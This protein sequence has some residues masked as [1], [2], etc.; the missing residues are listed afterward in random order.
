MSSR[1][2]HEA[3][4][5]HESATVKGRKNKNRAWVLI[6]LAIAVV[7]LAAF[8]YVRYMGFTT[9]TYEVRSCAEHLEEGAD[10]A[11]VQAAACDPAP[12]DGTTVALMRG[13]ESVAP[14][15]VDGSTL[16]WEDWALNSPQHAIEV[17]L[18]KAARSVVIAEP[19]GQRIRTAL[20][21]DA[22]DTVWG[23]FIGGRGATEYWILV[24]P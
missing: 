6:P 8:G 1:S 11:A 20:T 14:D 2:R 3:R 16:V 9:V 17:E 12:L 18:P 5:S 10:W 7:A 21:P 15:A 23:G 24:T 19:E 22:T 4:W 13:T